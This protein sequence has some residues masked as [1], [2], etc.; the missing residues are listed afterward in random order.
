MEPLYLEYYCSLFI[1]TFV[2]GITPGPNNM[3]LMTSGLNHGI[4]K[5]LPHYLGVCI[6]FPVM[7]AAIGFGMGAVFSKYPSIYLYLKISGIT[8]LFYLAWKIA[9]T[10]NPKTAQKI[11]KPFSFIQAA[12]FQWLNPKAWA[13]AVGA[14]AA[15]TSKENFT[16]N[17]FTVILAY[18]VMGLICMALWLKLGQSLKRFLQT[19]NRVN[20]F[21]IVMAVLLVL[22]V[23]PMALSGINNV[24]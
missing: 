24:A 16:V 9:N 8:Y 3:M 13:I 1:F 11:G 6:G 2:A 20:Y 23:I 14:L 17:V 5:S 18:L 19:G 4:R 7:V 22:S 15:F 12:A 10:G 21:N